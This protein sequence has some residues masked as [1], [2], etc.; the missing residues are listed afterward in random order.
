MPLWRVLLTMLLHLGIVAH[1]GEF[2]RTIDPSEL[3]VHRIVRTNQIFIR[4]PVGAND[5]LVG[6]EE[7]APALNNE[8]RIES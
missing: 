3:S 6:A 4:H 2:V 7:S 5:R 1:P 8:F